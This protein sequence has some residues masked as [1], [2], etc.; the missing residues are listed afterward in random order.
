MTLQPIIG[1]GIFSLQPLQTVARISPLQSPQSDFFAALFPS[2]Q[3]P[4][5]LPQ[6][7]LIFGASGGAHLHVVIHGSPFQRRGLSGW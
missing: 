5:A 2:N 3:G 1:A 6:K 4:L 7:P